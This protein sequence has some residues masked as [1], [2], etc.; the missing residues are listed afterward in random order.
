MLV[1]SGIV[2]VLRCEDS[3]FYVGWT[4]NLQSRYES[5]RD[6]KGADWTRLHK[7]IEILESYPNSSQE[8]EMTT[9][10]RLMR[11][12]GVDNVRGGP[13]VKRNLSSVDIEAIRKMNSHIMNKC[14][15][16]GGDHYT[17]SCTT[18]EPQQPLLPPQ[19]RLSTQPVQQELSFWEMLKAMVSDC[20]GPRPVC[21]RCG[22]N[23][24]SAG[25]C[26]AVRH[27]RGY[28]IKQRR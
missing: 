9:T 3:T 26:Y 12:Q 20:M 6:G 14:F 19:P 11:E 23:S 17:S 24:H 2:Y 18:P 1:M 15:T 25:S 13:W 28:V 10:L 22:R 16:C 27:L 5:H 21:A 7:P 4:T 8:F